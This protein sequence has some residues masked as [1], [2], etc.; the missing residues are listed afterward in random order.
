[1][2]TRA[3]VQQQDTWVKAK[4]RGW[5]EAGGRERDNGGGGLNE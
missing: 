2:L 3:K 4:E 5:T 1:M